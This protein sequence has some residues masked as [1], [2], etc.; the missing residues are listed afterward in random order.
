MSHH[1]LLRR[2][3][4]PRLRPGGRWMLDSGGFTELSMNGR[5]TFTARSYARAARRYH[6]EI[7]PMDACG[8]MDFMCEDEVLAATGLTVSDHQRLTIDNYLELLSL[9]PGLPWVPTLQGA[10]PS[11]YLRHARAWRDAGIDLRAVPLVGLGSVCRR[12]KITV[13]ML[14]MIDRLADQG[15]RLHA[16]GVKTTGLLACADKLV[17]SDSLAWSRAARWDGRRP[18]DPLSHHGN[19]VHEALAWRSALLARI[20]RAHPGIVQDLNLAA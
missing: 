7:G 18:G 3:T 1:A 13:P 16:F 6:D 5:W 11:D 17:S 15:V 2:V 12:T 10:R 19:S 9:E 8:Q 14:L 20:D 4:L